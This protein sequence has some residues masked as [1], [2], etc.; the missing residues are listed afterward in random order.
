MFVVIDERKLVTAGYNERFGSEGVASAGFS[1]D[2]FCE[3]VRTASRPDISAIEAFLVGDCEDQHGLPKIIREHSGAPVIVMKDSFS[4]NGTLEWFAAG[5]D[6]VVRKPV[7]VRELLARVGA[8]KRR[9]LP[10]EETPTHLDIRVFF[11]GRDPEVKGNPLALPRRERH[12][13][14][15]L[16]LNR[17]RRITKA[18]IFNA[19]YGIFDGEI[20]EDVIESHISKLRK[21]LRKLLGYD[22]IDSRRFLGYR[23][24]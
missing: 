19:V 11:D 22:P 23:L 15:H 13:L 7:H 10:K 21:K 24:K 6:D 2:E 20:E 14:E 3:W 1:A 8:I 5:V 18:Q 4:L 12:I 16:V 17:G 9:T